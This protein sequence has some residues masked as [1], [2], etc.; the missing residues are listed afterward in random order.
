[1]FGKIAAFELRYQIRQPIFWVAGLI[2][3]LMVFGS[4]TVDQIRIGSG[5]NIHRNS[6]SAIA[7][8]SLIMSLFFMFVST[9]FVANVIV[10]DDETGYGPIIRATPVRKFDYLFGRFTGAFGAVAL[11]FLAVPLGLFAGS[12]MPW[13]D[14]ETLGP[15]RI[16]DYAF[17]YLW[18]ALPSLFFSAALFFALT[19]V[20]RSMMGAYLGVAGF[21]VAYVVFNA[22]TRD[23]DQRRIAA[24]FEPFGLAA[25]GLA[26]R[27]FTAAEANTIS[28]A[29]QG[30][31]FWNRVIWT[32]AAFAILAL[33]YRL[34]RF[35]TKGARAR[36]KAAAESDAPPPLRMGALPAPSFGPAAAWAQL[37]KRTRFELGQVFKSPAFAVLVLMGAFNA[38][39][40]LLVGVEANGA[41]IYP[42]T[43]WA[44][45]TL[46]G[47]F[48]FIVI[49]V[50]IYY[51]GE[52]VWRERE[53]KTHE[54]VDATAV[55]DWAFVVPK[56]LA[57]ALVL[58][59]T[60]VIGVITAVAV[61]AIKGFPDIQL[62]KYLFWYVFPNA[63]D[64]TLIAIL[65]VF[66]QA[67]SPH[68]FVGWG[69]MV[70]YLISTLTLGQLGFEHNLYN[71]GGFP[72]VPLSD[73]NGQGKYAGFAAWFRA[74]W[75]CF[76]L[77][78][79]VLAYGLWRRGTETRLMPRLRRLPR[80]LAGP[81]GIIAGVALVSFVGL[82]GWI[83]LNTNVWNPYRTRIEG[84]Q[85]LADY[86][87]AF[88]KYEKLP[89]P[90]V[91]DVALD[92]DLH[93]H[94][95]RLVTHGTY[96]LVNDTGAPVND[97]HVRM[98]RDTQV[99]KISL[100]GASRVKTFDRFNYRIFSFDRPLLPGEHATLAFETVMAQHGFRNSGN[101]T[102][103]VD[104]GT[105]VD[106]FEFAPVIGM[107]RERLLQDRAKR[108]KYGL[109]PQLRPPK[110][111]DRS[112]QK[113]NY[114]GDASW[115]N[116]DITVHTEA[117]QTPIA[118]GYLV[119]D[120]TANGRRTIRY[121]T[122]A[123]VLNFFSVQ[124]ARYAIRRVNY[125]GVDLAIYYDPQH[126]W[127]VER[128]I[129]ALKTGLDY[130]QA[131]FS[132]YQFHQA[133]IVEF[134]DYAQFA[135]AFANT[136]PYSE[137]IGFIEDGTKPDKIDYPTYVTAHELAHQWWAHQVI[138]ADM[139]G[140]TALSE[141]LAQYSALI[142]MEKTYGPDGIRKFLKRELD[143]YLRNR[144]GEA[145]EE[146]PLVRVEDQPYIHY[147]KGSLVMYLLRDQMGEAKVNAAL[148]KVLGQ[149]AFKGAPYPRSQ[150][151]VDA[152]RDQAGLDPQAQ[153]LIT[154]LFAKITL[155]DLKTRT[156]V[157]HKRDDG[158]YDV[159]LTVDA[160]KMY[161]DG[162]GK[163]TPAT[164]ADEMFDIGVFTA[165]P[166]K[167][168]F[169]SGD[170]L[171]FQRRP[172]HTGV[173]SFTV[174]VDRPPKFAGLD[175]Y[176]KRIDRN[177]DDNDIAVTG[178]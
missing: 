83:Y 58:I 124:S 161:A 55:P 57:I 13:V 50:A 44:I 34:F 17:A 171:Y 68:K 99:T 86:E 28:P 26:T 132:P 100:T 130:Y 23:P 174:T 25:F 117:D 2:F 115:V 162:K 87:K 114:L 134:P 78:L 20:T 35:E 112:A 7:T 39:A 105:F 81:A 71:Y 160:R 94:E 137:G 74:Y 108:R 141:T 154:D 1:M 145:V 43:R 77:I 48:T 47:A 113:R 31:L 63:L 151:L 98:D 168:G 122:D 110:L 85:F 102:R 126:P 169:S 38:T 178:G 18:L 89:Q 107:G 88:L 67:I 139:Q 24:F 54:I 166:G 144:G 127:N 149:Y 36:P 125:K 49:I 64:L 135:Q 133:R 103:L 12:L 92:L 121:R 147:R 3:F 79:L 22:L 128:M 46:D 56:T 157:A 104:N 72:Q 76:A 96:Q 175:P 10:R 5:G 142:V 172:I 37:V 90:S 164:L 69:L 176:N 159:T 80:R 177:S 136:M 32:V 106:N 51:S 33:A 60:L 111:E 156:A 163:E 40:G 14:P 91:T 140:D 118:P 123:P 16:A 65:A 170:V 27:Y 150:D 131:N 42:V 29:I 9:A 52:L 129:T 101:T 97:L 6:P 15:N 167:K 119:S 66:L 143:Q 152:L 138:G 165:E 93:P 84:E 21:L 62:G 59:S 116:A 73:M 30:A 19:T 146:L 82:G 148:R 70:L 8:T 158:R 41:V 153:Q 109:P 4:V 53:R 95:P 120:T 45:Q 75:T 11:A 155:Y 173:Q 61:Q